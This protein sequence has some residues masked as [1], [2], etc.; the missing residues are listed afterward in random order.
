[1]YHFSKYPYPKQSPLII[2]ENKGVNDI[3]YLLHL[4]VVTTA[5]RLLR[6]KG[7]GPF[8]TTRTVP[9]T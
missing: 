7:D 2:V 9:S 4:A 8:A 1:T 6:D 3:I 5:A